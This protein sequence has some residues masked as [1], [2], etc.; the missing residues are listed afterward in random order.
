MLSGS[1]HESNFYVSNYVEENDSYEYAG[2]DINL[3]IDLIA[4]QVIEGSENENDKKS[5]PSSLLDFFSSSCSL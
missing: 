5:V 3:M 4:A 1:I 2:K